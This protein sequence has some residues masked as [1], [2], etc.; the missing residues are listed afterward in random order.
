MSRFQ[1]ELPA[2]GLTSADIRLKHGRVALRGAEAGIPGVVAFDGTLEVSTQGGTLIVSQP[3][4]DETNAEIVLPATVRDVR[5][6][7]GRGDLRLEDVHAQVHATS[8]WGDIVLA[9]GLG[10]ARVETGLGAVTIAAWQG[11]LT[12][13]S[14]AG[15]IQVDGAEEDVKATTGKGDISIREA[16]ACVE[17][18]TGLG[19]L[20][21]AGASG[22]TTLQTG[23][24]D[25]V[26]TDLA[27]ARLEAQ[28]GR[29]Q[30]VLGGRLAGL[31]A[32]T[33]KGDVVCRCALTAGDYD[34][35]SGSGN[36]NFDL[37]G[38]TELRVD[39]SVRHGHIESNLPLVKVGGYGPEGYFGRRLVGAV[40]SDPRVN[41][42]I[43]SGHGD[44]RI[45]QEVETVAP[46]APEPT[47]SSPQPQ[48]AQAAPQPQPVV[49]SASEADPALAILEAVS[50]GEVS[51]EE[52]L[53]LLGKKA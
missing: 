34:V 18:R 28:T 26:A 39:A 21:V 47:V 32:R 15:H 48:S 19:N 6:A 37:P 42:A 52:A 1:H 12:L 45:F 43:R 2:E 30:I 29:G 25:I 40:G 44:I 53:A 9:H 7:T 16:E 50:R 4:L 23:K 36:V 22:E 20:V 31:K 33:G 8:G 3:G 17:A 10:R 46:S 41:L 24:G 14:G 49:Q 13:A 5:C 11:P 51:V 35:K 27:G 38:N